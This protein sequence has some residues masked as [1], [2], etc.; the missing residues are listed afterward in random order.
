MVTLYVLRNEYA[1]KSDKP[2]SAFPSTEDALQQH[3]LRAKYQL[4]IWMQ[5]EVAKPHLL[6]PIGKG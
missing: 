6:N 3:A 1:C 4:F 5:C 2:A